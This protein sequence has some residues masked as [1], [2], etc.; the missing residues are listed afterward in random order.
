MNRLTKMYPSGKITLESAFFLPIHQSVIDS[1]I[2]NSVPFTVA[3]ERLKEYEDRDCN[4][5]EFCSTPIYIRKERIL[6]PVL[7]PLTPYGA[8]EQ[9][10]P[11]EYIYIKSRFC[12]MCGRKLRDS[13]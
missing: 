5:C 4:G 9:E 13:K 12:P 8:A 10:L 11:Y 3:V 1:E 7:A 6:T 2:R